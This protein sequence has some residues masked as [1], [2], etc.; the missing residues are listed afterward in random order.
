MA[1]VANSTRVYHLSQRNVTEKKRGTVRKLF[2]KDGMQYARVQWDGETKWVS[3]PV[4]NL[5]ETT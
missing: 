4:A 2:T 3:H 5:V 1:L